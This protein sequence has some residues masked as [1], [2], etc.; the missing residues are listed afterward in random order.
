MAPQPRP[1]EAG[2]FRLDSVSLAATKEVAVAFLS[3][4]YLDV[5]VH[6]VSPVRLCIQRTVI[7]GSRDRCLFDSFPR[8]FAV[9]HAL[10]RLLT[11]RHPP[12]ALSRLTTMISGSPSAYATSHK[13]TGH[14]RSQKQRSSQIAP[15]PNN[16]ILT[17]W[18][19]TSRRR[20]SRRHREITRCHSKYCQV[21]KEPPVTPKGNTGLPRAKRTV[22]RPRSGHASRCLELRQATQTQNTPPCP[23]KRTTGDDRVG[24][25]NRWSST[26]ERRPSGYVKYRLFLNTLWTF[27]IR[28]MDRKVSQ[29][30]HRRF[31]DVTRPPGR[32]NVVG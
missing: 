13:G 11:P 5:S 29:S 26:R 1:A 16:L 2:R 22:R 18:E 30:G 8:L 3:C 20:R 21:V 15:K 27:L 19:T 7:Q 6:R 12:Y 4:G 14:G 31:A 25:G 10:H 32:H 23:M 17:R 24:T 28:R 9:F